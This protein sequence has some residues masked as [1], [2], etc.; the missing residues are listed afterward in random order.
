MAST[1]QSLSR[2]RLCLVVVREGVA[3]IH[4]DQD[5]IRVRE[6]G[7][8][9]DLV[10]Q[11]RVLQEL[12][13][14]DAEDLSS[15]RRHLN[16]AIP[17]TSTEKKTSSRF[18]KRVLSSLVLACSSA[19]V[20]FRSAC[21]WTSRSAT[22]RRM[23]SRATSTGFGHVVVGTG[24]QYR[25][26][27]VGLILSRHHE[28]DRLVSSWAVAYAP[29]ELQPVD[30]GEDEVQQQ[31]M[32]ELYLERIPRRLPVLA[33]RDDVP[34]GAEDL[35]EQPPL[36]GIVLDQQDVKEVSVRHRLQRLR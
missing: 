6:C 23:L 21:V 8:I 17:G 29:G 5:R 14:L 28:D 11:V 31:Q 22:A 32:S 27:D 25:L 13:G 1:Q 33:C 2:G 30:A 16:E 15:G 34:A 9:E 7:R 24:L 10:P 18:S 20:A 26:E 35:R 36:T 19:W 4:L 12:F 3:R